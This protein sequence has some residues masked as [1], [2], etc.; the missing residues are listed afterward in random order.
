MGCTARAI[1]LSCLPYTLLLHPSS[2]LFCALDY[3]W[4]LPFHLYHSPPFSLLACLVSGPMVLFNS[5]IPD[6]Q[7]SYVKPERRGLVLCADRPGMKF[8]KLLRR[9]SQAL[10]CS[11][12]PAVLPIQNRRIYLAPL[13]GG[14]DIPLTHAHALGS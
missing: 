6:Y 3:Y 13:Y 7:G 2:P 5:Q 8:Q 10:L 12:F 1:V 9:Q 11:N 4:H 14:R